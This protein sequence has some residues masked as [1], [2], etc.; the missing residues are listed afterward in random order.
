MRLIKETLGLGPIEHPHI[1]TSFMP[2]SL[3]EDNLQP[4]VERWLARRR[5]EDDEEEK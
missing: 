2:A 3:F 1:T 5:I 4:E